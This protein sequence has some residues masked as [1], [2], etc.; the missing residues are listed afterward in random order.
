MTVFFI[1]F[2]PLDLPAFLQANRVVLLADYNQSE[3][4]PSLFENVSQKNEKFP[5]KVSTRLSAP[6]DA[7]KG[8]GASLVLDYTIPHPGAF[9]YVWVEHVKLVN[10]SGMNYLSFWR[11]LTGESRRPA[12]ELYVE[13][14]EDTDRNGRFDP[15][16]D[17]VARLPVSPYLAGEEKGDWR[18]VVIPL[19]RFRGIESWDRILRIAL[20]LSNKTR[21]GEGRVFVDEL[22][23]GS[24]FPEDFRGK[25]IPMQNR[26]SSFKINQQFPA[27][28]VK[29]KKK[30]PALLTL[31]L[32]FV[33]PYLEEIRWETSVDNGRTW[34]T[35]RSFYD[36]A[37]G[38]VY[39]GE[40]RWPGKGAPVT[41]EGMW[42]RAA[43]I[44]LWGEEDQFAGPYRITFN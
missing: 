27:E 34:Q 26:V 13:L 3:S 18:K 43:G 12:F 15:R 19:A 17:V 23:A 44:S 42:L 6:A 35:A 8:T 28:A 41:K 2:L 16:L 22:L 20:V 21:L 4:V 5:G 37:V 24:N 9:T 1:L 29:L 38:G 31:T 36:H 7:F 10:L 40:I 32:T 25:E 33:D 11:K 30:K 39:E 14:R